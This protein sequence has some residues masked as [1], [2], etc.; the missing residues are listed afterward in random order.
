MLFDLPRNPF[1][2]PRQ[3]IRLRKDAIVNNKTRT[4]LHC[5]YQSL[6]DLRCNDIWVIVE[7]ESEKI[8][9]SRYW[10]RSEEAM[11]LECNTG[12]QAVWKRILALL[13]NSREILDNKGRVW[14]LFRNCYASMPCGAADLKQMRTLLRSRTCQLE[15]SWILGTTYINNGCLA[16]ILPPVSI[17]QVVYPIPISWSHLHHGVGKTSFTIR[18]FCEMDEH[19]LVGVESDVVCGFIWFLACTELFVYLDYFRRYGEC[20][21]CRVPDLVIQ[22]F[23][24][25]QQS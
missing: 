12:S 17:Q 15:T 8:Y 11:F 9:I 1:L 3:S 20:F 10:L 24:A 13:D 6:Y 5:G 16:N 19:G 18:E 4:I 21:L 23:G 7:N 14:S 22:C 2:S 25:D